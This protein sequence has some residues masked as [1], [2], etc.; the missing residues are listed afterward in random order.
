MISNIQAAKPLVPESSVVELE[1]PIENTKRHR[2]TGI[3]LMPEK[4]IKAQDRKIRSEIHTL[5]NSI[6]NKEEFPEE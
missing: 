3:D 5:I 2:L 1:M 4:M 6:W